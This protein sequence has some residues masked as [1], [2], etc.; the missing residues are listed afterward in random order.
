MEKYRFGRKLQEAVLKRQEGQQPAIIIDGKEMKVRNPVFVGNRVRDVPCLVEEDNKAGNTGYTVVAVSFDNLNRQEKAWVCIQPVLLEQAIGSFMENHQME[1]I[2]GDCRCA[3]RLTDT[4][5]TG[6]DFETE[7]AMVEIKIPLV[8]PDG[9][10][11]F[12]WK[13]FYHIVRQMAGYCNSSYCEDKGKRNILLTIYQHGTKHIFAM[14]NENTKKELEKAV[15]VGVEFWIAET[16]TEEDG[17][18]LMSYQNFTDNIL[19][20]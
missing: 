8:V 10:D 9:T 13:G 14:V 19:K 12:I 7:N 6:F 1:D 3:N 18:S 2:T 11:S 5:D 16:K 17:I 15:R 20:G 4:K